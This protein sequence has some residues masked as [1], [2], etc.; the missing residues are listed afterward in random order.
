VRRFAGFLALFALVLATLLGV[1]LLYLR[2]QIPPVSVS[3]PAFTLL[4]DSAVAT[5]R[6]RS[7]LEIATSRFA[8]LLGPPPSERALTVAYIDDPKQ[9]NAVTLYVALRRSLGARPERLPLPFPTPRLA[10][11]LAGEPRET[12]GVAAGGRGLGHEV[13]HWLLRE[14]LERFARGRDRDSSSLISLPAWL[15]EGIAGFCEADEARIASLLRV[16]QALY[17]SARAG[18]FDLRRLLE[19]PPPLPSPVEESSGHH[20]PVSGADAAFELY[21]D[22]ALLLVSYLEARHPGTIARL[23]KRSGDLD[24]S[25]ETSVV[26]DRAA[27]LDWI[28]SVPPLSL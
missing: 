9:M 23:V 11:L 3:T 17:D 27:F 14:Y 7:D 4:A 21:C 2:G 16:R 24:N 1:A 19:E 26:H 18:V 12:V 5:A 20:T 10:K 13:G 28:R 15:R 6:P 8:R 25:F 22:E